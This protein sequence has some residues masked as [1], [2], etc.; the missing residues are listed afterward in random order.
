MFQQALNVFVYSWLL[1]G[2]K[3]D[4]YACEVGWLVTEQL[5]E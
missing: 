4:H 3:K 5:P 2:E 1:A